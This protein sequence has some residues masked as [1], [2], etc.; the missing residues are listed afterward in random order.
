[1]EVLDN[2]TFQYLKDLQLSSFCHIA[3]TTI[4]ENYR[5]EHGDF[6]F[7]FYFV[8]VA[9]TKESAFGCGYSEREI[10]AK[11]DGKG[12]LLFT[13]QERIGSIFDVFKILNVKLP[14]DYMELS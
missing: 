12:I 7:Y 8:R 4:S 13:E 5:A 10:N 11:Y 9:G 1:M 6:I 3:S 14:E 2:H